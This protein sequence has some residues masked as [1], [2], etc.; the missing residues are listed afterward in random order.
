MR[1]APEDLGLEF[2]QEVV[3]F[4]NPAGEME[5]IPGL[6]QCRLYLRVPGGFLH[7][8]TGPVNFGHKLT[9][10]AATL[11]LLPHDL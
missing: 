11:V 8:F 2:T 4:L 7:L 6:M 3:G 10:E 5:Y 1:Y 9:T